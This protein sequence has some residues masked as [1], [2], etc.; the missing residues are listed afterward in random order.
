MKTIIS[1]SVGLDSTYALWKLLS[2]TDEDI[3]AVFLTPGDLVNVSQLPY[4][5][6]SYD[7]VLDHSLNYDR[8]TNIANWLKANVRDFTLLQLP[9]ETAL[10]STEWNVPNSPVA[11]VTKYAVSKINANLCDKVIITHER[12][13]DGFAN[14]GTIQSRRPASA[15]CLDLFKAEATRGEISFP[16][17]DV[18]YTQANALVEMPADLVSLTSSCQ[19][20]LPE[21]CGTCFKCEKRQFFCDEIAAGKTPTQIQ[22]YV[23]QM[24]V[25]EAGKWMSMKKWLFNRSLPIADAWETPQWPSSYTVP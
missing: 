9:V 18:Q 22:D 7:M 1:F 3:T 24:S 6:R 20:N 14:G 19:L 5:L 17:L 10:L 2:S 16:M 21:P 8:A 4:D 13:N 15:A 25:P 23:T 11:Y 12:E